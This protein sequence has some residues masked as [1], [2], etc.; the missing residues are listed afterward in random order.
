M[1]LM[2]SSSDS[3]NAQGILTVVYTV[4]N[5]VTGAEQDFPSY[6]AAAAYVNA[7]GGSASNSSTIGNNVQ[8]V[9]KNSITQAEIDAVKNSRPI[10][11]GTY[12][13]N[14]LFVPGQQLTTNQLAAVQASLATGN[15]IGRAHV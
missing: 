9:E 11:S 13:G 10:V 14:Q 8:Y 6:A 1:A 12:I 5:T 3:F 15:Q 7:N 2:I 4:T